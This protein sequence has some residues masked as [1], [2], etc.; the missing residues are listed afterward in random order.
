MLS[1]HATQHG[2]S[3]NE[4]F[5]RCNDREKEETIFNLLCECQAEAVRRS[6]FLGININEI[7]GFVAILGILRLEGGSD[8]IMK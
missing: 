6:R 1:E 7:S 8:D 3:F 2:L 5:R 4:Y